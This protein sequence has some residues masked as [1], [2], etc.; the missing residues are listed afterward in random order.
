MLAEARGRRVGWVYC[1]RLPCSW[2]RPAGTLPL[3]ALYRCFPAL[4][5]LSR[6]RVLRM[7]GCPTPCGRSATLARACWHPSLSSLSP[8]LSLAFPDP[9]AQ[10]WCA[11][12]G[13]F[14]ARRP[15]WCC[16][17]GL[18]APLPLSSPSL[19]A[20]LAIV[21]PRAIARIA[22]GGVFDSRCPGGCPGSVTPAP[23]PLVAYPLWHPLPFPAPRGPAPNR[24]PFLIW[25][26]VAPW[27][28][29]L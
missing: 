21:C 10:P 5:A 27:R 15:G 9:C 11:D 1:V 24:R 16:G 8:T 2:I 29:Y 22:D 13:V 23:H 7:G 3:I 25:L 6:L 20:A 14:V 12:G 18:P 19:A 4:P 26:A 28:E 17:R